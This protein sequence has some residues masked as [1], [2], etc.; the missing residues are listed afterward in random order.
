MLIPNTTRNFLSPFSH[1]H[2]G[3]LLFHQFT[4]LCP[5]ALPVSTSKFLPTTTWYFCFSDLLE[6]W[7][8]ILWGSAH[9]GQMAFWLFKR[10]VLLGLIGSLPFCSILVTTHFSGCT[11]NW[12]IHFQDYWLAIISFSTFFTWMI[13]FFP[14]YTKKYIHLNKNGGSTLRHTATEEKLLTTYPLIFEPLQSAHYAS[15][16]ISS[17][18]FFQYWSTEITGETWHFIISSI[19]L[20]Q[21]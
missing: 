16:A 1:F 14:P 2:R 6:L 5:P 15:V 11:Y 3:V 17:K 9:A 10:I 7:I 13:T 20:F 12:L 8:S 19:I 4:K 18:H 21:I